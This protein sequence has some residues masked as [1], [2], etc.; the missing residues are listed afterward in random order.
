MRRR[1][2]K[3]LFRTF[4]TYEFVDSLFR[5]TEGQWARSSWYRRVGHCTIGYGTAIGQDDLVRYRDTCISTCLWCRTRSLLSK[6]PGRML[7]YRNVEKQQIKLVLV[8][9]KTKHTICVRRS[10]VELSVNE[11]YYI[12]NFVLRVLTASQFQWTVLWYNDIN[13]EPSL[14]LTFF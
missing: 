9:T 8:N 1:R 6:R 3:L 5:H 14:S 11:I 2:Y 12:A 13:L 10:V 4:G 7:H